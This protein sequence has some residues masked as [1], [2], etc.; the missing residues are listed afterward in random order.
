[1]KRKKDRNQID[2]DLMEEPRFGGTSLRTI[3]EHETVG[4]YALPRADKPLFL[5]R[6]KYNDFR[7]GRNLT[8]S[9]SLTDAFLWK[10]AVT[11]I[12]IVLAFVAMM[13]VADSGI[14]NKGFVNVSILLA[15][16]F[17]IMFSSF[18]VKRSLNKVTE[19]LFK[20]IIIADNGLSQEY[21]NK[22]KQ[23]N[24]ATPVMVVKIDDNSNPYRVLRFGVKGAMENHADV[25]RKIVEP[26]YHAHV[27]GAD[28]SEMWGRKMAASELLTKLIESEYR[29]EEERRRNQECER[30]RAQ[31][32]ALDEATDNY[33]DIAS[34]VD[35]IT[36][37]V[38][39]STSR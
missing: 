27:S 29:L 35:S 31:Q 39:R 25:V 12:L 5:K 26:V 37:K 24:R 28:D 14:G 19:R 17:I 3:N 7:I 2:I 32:Q 1:M 16:V 11:A 38:T 21:V 10:H 13:K 20:F 4:V 9:T 6:E 23:E 30:V 34:E 18:L 33:R 8:N 15:I 22:V 36:S